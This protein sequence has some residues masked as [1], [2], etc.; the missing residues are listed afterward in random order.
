VSVRLGAVEIASQPGSGSGSFSLAG[1]STYTV[2]ASGPAGYTFAVGGDCAS[3]GSVTLPLSQSRDCTVTAN[4][5]APRLTVV[6]QVI[7]DHGGAAGPGSFT[8]RVRRGG[9]DVAG[10]P[11]PGS[12]S[13]TV[14]TL[15]AGTHV[16]SADP[17]AGYGS[18][19]SG[20]CAGDGSV[21]LG[22]GESRTCTVTANDD[23]PAS[24]P[25]IRA[26][27]VPPPEPGKSV[28]AFPES[29]TVKVKLPGS[30]A[31][32]DLEEAQQLPVGTVIDARKGHVT[33][34]AA[35]DNAG[36]TA[37]AEFW[38]GIF[39]LGQTKGATP[40]TVLTL[41]EKLACPRAGR[42]SLAAKRKKKRRLWGDGSGKFQTKGKH[43]AATVVGTR[44]L[45]EDK[46]KSTLTRV[47]RGRVSVRDFVKRKTVIVRAGKKYVARAKKS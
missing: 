34:V 27:Q 16:V 43:S 38:A 20:D 25:P 2:A 9:A 11:Q 40:T 7:N 1:N 13:G 22:V 28:N 26:Q 14:Y 12:S 35:A 36:G 46:C 41:V 30:A 45:V 32:V 37:T 18:A 33:L 4:D 47:V 39:R 31:Y 19:I 15:A 42:A 5:V 10:S 8:V 6:T 23:P 44:W 3:D 21:T 29:G 24:Q 17:L